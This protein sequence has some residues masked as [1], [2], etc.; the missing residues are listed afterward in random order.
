MQIPEELQKKLVDISINFYKV[1]YLAD[2]IVAQYQ[3][4]TVNATV[5]V[6]KT[7]LKMVKNSGAESK[8]RC[9]RN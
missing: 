2:A 7:G 8:E 9:V 4:P 1:I 5:P 3:C 6:Q